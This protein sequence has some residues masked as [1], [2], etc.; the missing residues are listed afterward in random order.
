MPHTAAPTT[1]LPGK[2]FQ[3]EAFVVELQVYKSSIQREVR[4]AGSSAAAQADATVPLSI[5]YAIVLHTDDSTVRFDTPIT[6]APIFDI[7]IDP[8]DTAATGQHDIII[9]LVY[10]DEVAVAIVS[11]DVVTN[12]I[13]GATT[14]PDTIPDH[15]ILYD[16][17]ELTGAVDDP[18]PTLGLGRSTRHLEQSSLT[19]QSTI[20]E[21][22]GKRGA[23]FDGVDDFYNADLSISLD[24]TIGHTLLLG[25]TALDVVGGFLF[26]LGT[27]FFDDDAYMSYIPGSDVI[28]TT[29]GLGG[30]PTSIKT[31]DPPIVGQPAVYAR[32]TNDTGPTH[33]M[34][35]DGAEVS[36][37]T[38]PNP[39]ASF[40]G[41]LSK[42]MGCGARADGGAPYFMVLYA[43]YV[44]RRELTD[45]EI[46][47]LSAHIRGL[48]P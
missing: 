30:S 14:F 28:E 40:P 31:W 17:L 38:D 23:L 43:I 18:L 6:P 1:A 48:M 12:P 29:V 24:N 3:G 5:T 36:S 27:T 35:I 15:V 25:F 2:T 42:P 41:T 19:L 10:T 46:T 8:S 7:P 33:R 45:T 32:V 37:I 11:Y 26:Q 20:V 9:T 4:R 16:G 44:Y 22:S 34:F 13:T 39:A 47:D 21:S